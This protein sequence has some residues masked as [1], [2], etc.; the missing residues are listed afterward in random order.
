MQIKRKLAAM[1]LATALFFSSIGGAVAM[2]EETVMPQ[3][4]ATYTNPIVEDKGDPFVMRWNGRYYL[5][6]SSGSEQIQCWTSTDLVNW[7]YAGVCAENQLLRNAYAPEVVYYNGYFYMYTSP[8]GQGHY[9]LRSESPTGPFEIITGNVGRGIDGDVFIDDDGQWYFLT[10]GGTCITRYSM[11]SPSDFGDGLALTAASMANS[12]TEG[13]MV[14]KHD[15]LYYLT[16]TG[17]HVLHKGYRIGYAVGDSMDSLTKAT[18]TLLVSTIDQVF[19]PGHSSTVKGPD[20]DSYYLVYHTLV[21]AKNGSPTRKMNID[22]LVFNGSTMEVLG[23]TYTPQPVPAQPDLQTRFEEEGDLEAW[24]GGQLQEGVLALESD[25]IVLSRATYT[26]DFTAEFCLSGMNGLGR[27]G[28]VFAYQDAKNYVMALVDATEQML[29]VRTVSG[30]RVRRTDTLALPSSFG[31]AVRVDCVQALQVE[32]T[33]QTYTFFLNDHDLGSLT[34]PDSQGLDCRIGFYAEDTGLSVSYAALTGQVHGNS[35]SE[36]AKPLPGSIQAKDY[37]SPV[38]EA[39]VPVTS[40]ESYPDYYAVDSKRGQAYD[41]Q[42]NLAWESQYDLGLRY[43]AEESVEVQISVDGA[44]VYSGILPATDGF[45]TNVLRRI[46]LP[47]GIH[48]VTLTYSSHILAARLE[49]TK[50]DATDPTEITYDSVDDGNTYYDGPWSVTDGSLVMADGG[51]GVGKR[52]YGLDGWGD[53]SVEADFTPLGSINC[54]LLVRTTNPDSGNFYGTDPST[55]AITGTDYLQGYFIG[56]GSGGVAIGKQDYNWTPVATNTVPLTI[57]QGQTYRIRVDC[58]GANIKVYVDG[59]LYIDYTDPEPFLNGRVGM[60]THYSAVRFDNLTVTPLSVGLTNTLQQLMA[61]AKALDLEDAEAEAKAALEA[62][63]AEG[64]RIVRLESATEAEID[65]AEA[66][67]E[68]AIAAL[69]QESVLI[70]DMNADGSLSVTDVVLL[71]KSIL[72]N[73]FVATGDVSGDGSLTVTDVVLLRKAILT[74]SV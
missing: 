61:A 38:A 18:D 20:L 41:Y 67:L 16:Y 62:A 59:T 31:E 15:G 65:A 19:G 42:V 32:S 64:E 60:R 45:A 27:A 57:R 44:P 9:V 12:W 40:D 30:G 11:S 51:N 35:A 4:T 8:D 66:A 26:G 46:P 24:E 10:S 49:F 74:Q 14:V 56:F 50:Y 5:Y 54:G 55:P 68:A 28:V 52:L 22:R 17:N 73:A 43:Q 13:P 63:L 7:E 6:P 23:P 70:G 36:Q 48:T 34:L 39:L 53:Y 21:E 58:L 72:H 29:V 3:E 71:R 2:K 37:I 25:E 69:A 33:G 1:A 47:A